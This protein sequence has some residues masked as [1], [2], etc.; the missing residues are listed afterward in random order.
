MAEQQMRLVIGDKNNSSWSLRPWLAMKAFGIP[1]EETKIMLNQEDTTEK[2]LQYSPS[3]KV[4]CLLDGG[5]LVWESLAIMEYLNDKFPEK[6]MWPKDI[7]ARAWARSVANEMHG[8][9][10]T[11]RQTCPHKIKERF[12]NYDYSKAQKDIDRIEALWALCLDFHK[13]KGPFLFG[14]FSLA[15]CMYAPV[16][17]RFRAYDVKVCEKSRAYMEAMLAHPFMKEWEAEALT[18]V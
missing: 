11:L 3:G 12:P 10:Q 5:L 2:I 1:F 6:N 8:G 14:E 15:D 18:E 17:N 9:F 7:K 16:V 13:S 4:P